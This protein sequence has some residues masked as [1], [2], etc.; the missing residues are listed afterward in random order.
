MAL[1]KGQRV[2]KGDLILTIYAEN[3]Q[4]LDLAEKFA[5]ENKPYEMESVLLE[6]FE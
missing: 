2:R 5:N 1:V 3:Q 6:S 4:K